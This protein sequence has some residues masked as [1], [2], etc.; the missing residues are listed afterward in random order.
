MPD[1]PTLGELVRRLA[2][3][4]TQL[5]AI[6]TQLRTDFVRKETFDEIRK[7]DRAAFEAIRGDIRDLETDRA[8]DQKW[9]R[10]AS[11]TVAVAAVGWLLTII[12]LVLAVALR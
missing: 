10:T 3:I 5:S 6:S 11:V 9:R 8:D 4:T 7:A 1:E 12:G 2:D